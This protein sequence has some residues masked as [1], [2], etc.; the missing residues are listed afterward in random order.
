M[1]NVQKDA[2]RAIFDEKKAQVKSDL[3]SEY[4]QIANQMIQEP[5]ERMAQCILQEES[6]RVNAYIRKL[7]KQL[8]QLTGEQMQKLGV[9]QS[10]AGIVWAA[11]KNQS[12]LPRA[13]LCQRE[14]VKVPSAAQK[15]S[16]SSTTEQKQELGKMVNAR[17][18]SAS[19]AAASAVAVVVTCLVVPGWPG[20]AGVVKAA[21]LVVVGAGAAGAFA[22]QQRIDEINRIVSR[23]QQADVSRQDVRELAKQVC[24]H[25]CRTNAQI[26][27]QWLDVER[28]TLIAECER[29]LAR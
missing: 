28:E 7:R 23:S 9:S 16:G 29:E 17:N 2:L 11:V 19:I 10:A 14:D 18:V 4:G 27:E 6:P 21:E 12:E 1:D 5:P 13:S 15:T 22:S 26:I 24:T 3:E 20:A 8:Q 25:Q